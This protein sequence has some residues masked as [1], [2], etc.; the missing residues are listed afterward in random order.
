MIYINFILFLCIFLYFLKKKVDFVN[1]YLLFLWTIS[2]LFSILYS[3]SDIFRNL[4]KF[5]LLPFVYLAV[6][7]FIYFI[8]VKSSPLKKITVCKSPLLMPIIWIIS[9][10]A[11]IPFTEIMYYFFSGGI[12]FSN[13]ADI[14]DEY[15][16]GEYDAREIL[17]VFSSK[18]YGFSAY[19]WFLSPIL[20][21]YY[22]V[23]SPSTK[24]SKFFASGLIISYLNPLLLG[25]TVG[26]RGALL[27]AL[28]YFFQVF[29]FFR[30]VIPRKTKKIINKG[31]FIMSIGIMTIFLIIT[32]NR[33]TVDRYSNY[34]I[35]DWFYRYL[36]ES[37][38]NF[39]T[40]CWYTR[41]TTNGLNCFSYFSSFVGGDGQRD[42]TMLEKITGT[43][44][45][46]YNTLFGDL[47]YDFGHIVTIFIV[48]ILSMIARYLK[49][50]NGNMIL[51]NFFLYS[52]CFYILLSG[53]LIWPL[54]TK[55]HSF[56]G[57]ILVSIILYCTNNMM[58]DRRKV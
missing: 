57:T 12:D 42:Y 9:C 18:L 13:I 15:T 27:W 30:H 5:T 29:L 54:I 10:T 56:L 2:A 47:L 39:N 21:F 1:L 52:V 11:Y 34:S 19:S 23:I 32:I 33:F 43:R 44:M 53:F 45:N 17:S 7:F 40:E 28:L 22:L 6:L 49:P 26:T 35:T 14:K 16:S 55:A 41:G 58:K 24:I 20:F 3:Q 46:V 25:M 37:F 38:C 8:N 31:F 48:I 50:K 4:H 51:P 36:G